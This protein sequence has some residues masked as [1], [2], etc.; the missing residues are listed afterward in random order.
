M[1]PLRISWDDD[2]V[3][4][5]S[6]ADIKDQLN[7]DHEEWNAKIELHRAGAARWAEN[8]MHR[9]I[10]SK[11]HYW[12]L[13]D[14][15]RGQDQSIRLP[16]GK[17]QS[18]T[19]ILY[20]SNNSGTTLTGPS[21]SSPE[22]T[23]YREDLRGDHGGTLYPAYNSTWPSVDLEAPSPVVITFTAGWLENEVPADIKHA[24]MM[25]ISDALEITGAVDLA[26]YT[27]LD[28]KN[29]LLYPWRILS[30]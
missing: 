3:F 7:I 10:A 13:S 22:G 25:Y 12:V 8:I 26:Q 16:R 11:T 20:T 2:T 19:S 4:P 6:A 14:F 30:C 29:N 15:P 1:R 24:M 17:T 9:S 21:S 5:I 27:N 28:A 23:D 18:V